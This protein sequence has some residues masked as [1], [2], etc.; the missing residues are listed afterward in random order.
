MFSWDGRDNGG[1]VV[2]NG[3]YYIHIKS[4]SIDET[5]PVAIFKP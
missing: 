4:A 3:V 5:K 1:S 2:S